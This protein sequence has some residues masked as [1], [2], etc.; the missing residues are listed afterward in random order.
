MSKV[1][2]E[3]Q[4]VSPDNIWQFAQ[5]KPSRVCRDLEAYGI[6]PRIT[7][8]VLVARGVTKWLAVRRDLIRYKN[9]LKAQIQ[10]LYQRHEPRTRARSSGGQE[11]NPAYWYARGRREAFE[12]CRKEIRAM[13]HSQRWRWP[14]HDP[15]FRRLLDESPPMRGESPNEAEDQDPDEA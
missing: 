10:E 4:S 9:R 1:S 6:S 12:E 2:D 13:C 15:R 5:N 11:P 3:P 7:A 14:D 8:R